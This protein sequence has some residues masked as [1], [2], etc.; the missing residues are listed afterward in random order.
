MDAVEQALAEFAL[1]A[2]RQAKANDDEFE[3]DVHVSVCRGNAVFRLTVTETA[4]SHTICDVFSTSL[5]ETVKSAR[6]EFSACLK[7]FDYRE[8]S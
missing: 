8:V 4:D 7:S 5:A 2:D 3:T 6:N 1:Y